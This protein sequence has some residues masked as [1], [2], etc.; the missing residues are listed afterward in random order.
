MSLKPRQI[1]E[2]ILFKSVLRN[3]DLYTICQATRAWQ[4]NNCTT[5]K[6]NYWLVILQWVVIQTF[7]GNFNFNVFC[8]T[9]ESASGLTIPKVWS[10]HCFN[11]ICLL[12]RLYSSIGIY[13]NVIF[14]AFSVYIILLETFCITCILTV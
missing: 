9:Y 7:T 2:S 11:Y 5:L 4:V 3:R 10:M 13:I 1:S 12:L 14:V 8:T 6:P